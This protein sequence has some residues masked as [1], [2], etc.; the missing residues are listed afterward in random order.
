MLII[1][2]AFAA[3]AP[4]A[5]ATPVVVTAD[6][7]EESSQATEGAFAPMLNRAAS[8]AM[9]GE[10]VEARSLYAAIEKMHAEYKLE[11]VDGR[12]MYPAEIARRGMLAIDTNRSATRLAV[13]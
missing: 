5:P 11:T 2:A 3:A 1:A 7:E 8:L 4:S 10:L 6:M 13:K 12:W 9:Q